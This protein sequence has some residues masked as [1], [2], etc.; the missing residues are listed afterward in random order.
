MDLRKVIIYGRYR[1]FL[2]RNVPKSILKIVCALD[3]DIVVF[4]AT[5]LVMSNKILQSSSH[6]WP[7][8]MSEELLSSGITAAV[9]TENDR[10]ADNRSCPLSEDEIE[11]PSGRITL[12]P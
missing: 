8:G 5:N 2:N 10:S 11:D 12:G 4:T 9:W 7:R 6:N 3:H 1:L